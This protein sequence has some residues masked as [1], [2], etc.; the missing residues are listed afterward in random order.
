MLETG[1]VGGVA[2]NGNGYVFQLHNRNAF[3][4]VICAVAFNFRSRAVGERYAVNYLNRFGIGV[5]TRSAIGKA[6]NSRNYIRR[7]L[8]ESV[9]DNS[10]GLYAY[11]VCVFCNLD[12]AF[13]RREG[14]VTCQKAEA[15]GFFG[16]EHRAKIAV[17][18]ADLSVFRNR[19][20][21]T[22]AL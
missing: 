6:V 3:G 21:D 19:A 11:F 14:F 12:C 15:I 2:R 5:E 7:V 8:A 17:T 18:E 20:G 1:G 10:K 4:N 13:R 16:K 22:E 9:K